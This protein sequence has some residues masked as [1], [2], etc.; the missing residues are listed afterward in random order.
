M[1]RVRHGFTLMELLL[2]I[3]ILVILAGAA[4]PMFMGRSKAAKIDLAKSAIAPNGAIGVAMEGFHHDFDRYP[5]TEEGLKALQ[6]KPDGDGYD[7]WVGYLAKNSDLKDPWG[8]EYV[9]VCTDG[10]AG[11]H[12]KEGY[13]LSSNGPDKQAGTDDDVKNWTEESGTNK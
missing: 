4:I 3:A 1:R 2:V 12:N 13:D 10:K 11:E 9:Y 6:V 7:K 5:T 8:V